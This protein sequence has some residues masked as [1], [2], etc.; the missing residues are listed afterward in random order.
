MD[1]CFSAGRREGEALQA[2]KDGGRSPLRVAD[3]IIS[4]AH[5]VGGALL[6]TSRR[7]VRPPGRTMQE[8]TWT[9]P[10]TLA[11]WLS[12]VRC[13]LFFLFLNSRIICAD[14]SSADRRPVLQ[15][16][17]P[18]G[19]RAQLHQ[20]AEEAGSRPV[21]RSLRGLVEQHHGGRGEDPQAWYASFLLQKNLADLGLVVPTS[22]VP[23]QAPWTPRTSCERLSS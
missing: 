20:A 3:E 15:H 13:V 5:R 2:E 4:N 1:S 14:G 21:W 17:G 19:D 18:M 11:S 10:V 8:G 7:S 22:V 6:H 12:P 16:G 9:H 23:L